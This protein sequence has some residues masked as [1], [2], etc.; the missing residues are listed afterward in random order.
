MLFRSTGNTLAIEEMIDVVIAKAKRRRPIAIAFTIVERDFTP[1][2]ARSFTKRIL[3]LCDHMLGNDFT[4]QMG[5]DS[6]R[7]YFEPPRPAGKRVGTMFWVR[8]YK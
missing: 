7:S 6:Y 1:G 5:G 8:N 4:P 3:A 2:G